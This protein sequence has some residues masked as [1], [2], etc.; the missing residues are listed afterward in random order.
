M[1]GF[2]MGSIKT[3]EKQTRS[4]CT[5]FPFRATVTQDLFGEVQIHFWLRDSIVDAAIVSTCLEWPGRGRR[6]MFEMKI[7]QEQKGTDR[8]LIKAPL[9]EEYQPSCC[10]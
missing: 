5:D 3:V 9:G 8:N 7:C 4:V 2:Q 6:L 10:D 1:Q